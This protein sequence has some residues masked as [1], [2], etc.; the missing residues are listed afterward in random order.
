MYAID[1]DTYRVT[2]NFTSGDSYTFH[3]VV[4]VI[5]KSNGRVVIVQR[6]KTHCTYAHVSSI[7]SEKEG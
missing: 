3:N 7:I 2:L 5:P 1:I 4:E 6:D